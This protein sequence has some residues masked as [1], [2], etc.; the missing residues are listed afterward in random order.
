MFALYSGACINIQD[1]QRKKGATCLIFYFTLLG[2]LAGL[3]QPLSHGCFTRFYRPLLASHVNSGSWVFSPFICPPSLHGFPLLYA[4]YLHS[5][6]PVR[7]AV[8]Q[9]AFLLVTFS[10]CSFACLQHL[11]AP[12]TLYTSSFLILA[13]LLQLPN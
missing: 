7:T 8:C 10:H 1:I 5:A 2:F 12:L 9:P 6:L 3:K 11:P 4:T 13:C